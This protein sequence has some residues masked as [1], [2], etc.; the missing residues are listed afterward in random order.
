MYRH[1]SPKVGTKDKP[2]D[3]R[4]KPT[5]NSP[6]IFPQRAPKKEVVAAPRQKE[7]KN[8]G[9]LLSNKPAPPPPG[10]VNLNKSSEGRKPGGQK[11]GSAFDDYYEKKPKVPRDK[12]E[13]I[14][15]SGD[16]YQSENFNGLKKAPNSPKSLAAERSQKK[17]LVTPI[18]S[19]ARQSFKSPPNRPPQRTDS[20]EDK[21]GKRILS[22]GGKKLMAGRFLE[23]GDATSKKSGEVSTGHNTPASPL[24]AKG[25]FPGLDVS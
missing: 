1:L 8:L 19:D 10:L 11:T 24:L 3:N 21:S 14:S 7:I 4:L 2:D 9:S 20:E 22:F 17:N 25:R 15:L 23:D 13:E 6:P 5:T 18:P 12:K 16:S